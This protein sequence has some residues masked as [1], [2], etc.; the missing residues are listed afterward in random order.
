MSF[1][2]K[3]VKKYYVYIWYIVGTRE[4]FY[5]GKGSNNRV[6]SMKNRN[7]YFKNIRKRYKC[8][9]VIIE[10]FEDEDDAYAFEKKLGLEFK[11]IGQAKACYVL[12]EIQKFID[13]RTRKKISKTLIG[14]IPWNKGRS[15]SMEYREKISK[16]KKGVPLGLMHRFSISM[17]LQGQKRSDATKKALSEGKIGSKNP[18]FGK[19]PS[20][21]TIEK[22]R[23]KIIGHPV[24]EGTKRKIGLSNGIKVAMID[25][26][27]KETIKT[28]N[29]ASEA[30]RE[31][32]LNNSKISRVC[33]G[34]RK[35]SGGF[36]WKY[37]ID[38]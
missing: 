19:S 12:G 4:V 17:A 21:E 30:A 23:M 5:V 11:K 38:N 34:E 18:M 24:S 10:Y 3:I 20:K 33:R 2:D 28:Y 35:T 25:P 1:N 22:R 13:R 29:S 6:T 15:M 14:N 9:Y 7:N 26:K 32:N 31:N 27:T 37:I 36:N 8:D 16:A